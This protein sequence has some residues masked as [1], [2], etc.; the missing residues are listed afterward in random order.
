VESYKDLKADPNERTQQLLEAILHK[1]SDPSS[2]TDS[3]PSLPFSASTSVVI[4][5]TLFFLSLCVSLLAALGAILIKQWARNFYIGL[6]HITSPRRR[7]RE[8]YRR[9][10]AIKEYKFTLII[11]WIPMML[12]V[13]LFL[14]LAGLV[15]WLGSQNTIVFITISIVCGSSLMIYILGAVIPSF[16]QNAPFK[17]PVAS[18]L[19]MTPLHK[20]RLLTAPLL[21]A[22]EVSVVTPESS[23]LEIF[24]TPVD[25]FEALGHELSDPSP[26]LVDVVL[27]SEFLEHAETNVEVEAAL[28]QLR[29]MLM[30][31]KCR[32]E[33]ISP[34]IITKFIKRGDSD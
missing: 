32:V 28:D 13:S 20:L 24:A 19:R 21:S 17:W 26:E 23:K 12:H 7:A 33:Q 9:A 27:I 30:S 6:H 25:P 8:R 15:I 14:F 34:D 3:L 22:E 18:L 1:M 4:T 16:D 2:P 11:A 10:K 31:E 5:N 29:L